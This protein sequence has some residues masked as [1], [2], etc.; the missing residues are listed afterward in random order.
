MK[1]PDFGLKDDRIDFTPEKAKKLLSDFKFLAKNYFSHPSYL[2]IKGRPVAIIY[3][4][5]TFIGD[6][7]GAINGLRKGLQEMGFNPFLIGDEIFWYVMRSNPLPPSTHPEINR[8]NLFD[9]ITAYN[10][11][12]WAKPKQMGYGK[13]S[14]FLSEVQG[15]YRE[16]QSAIGK[17]IMLIPSI[18]PGYNDRGVRLSENHPV[19]P[20]QFQP[21]GAEGSFF[22][23][24]LKQTV[25]PF[26]NPENPLALITSFNEWNEG[27][28]IEPTQETGVTSQ[29]YSP[30]KTELY[31]GIYLPGIWGAI[32]FHPSGYLYGHKRSGDG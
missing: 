27:T 19:I 15:L 32:S 16:Y 12:N 29:D 7:P 8:I 2:K 24:A 31:P 21:D 11:Y 20:R 4:T 9:G 3:L 23:Q 25:L 30:T 14:T 28:Q 22:D 17:K 5:R 10:M 6:Y 26:M 13:Q 18:I 1:P